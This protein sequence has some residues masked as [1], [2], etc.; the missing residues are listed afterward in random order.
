MFWEAALVIVYTFA[1]V[2]ASLA[3]FNEHSPLS[4][5]YKSKRTFFFTTNRCVHV[6]A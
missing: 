6:W 4:R 3:L 1:F 2:L 5:L